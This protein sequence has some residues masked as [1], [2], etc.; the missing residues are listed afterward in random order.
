[1]FWEFL[2]DEL[3]LYLLSPASEFKTFHVD[4]T[5]LDNALLSVLDA[6]MTALSPPTISK[7][8]VRCPS[9]GNY[10]ENMV[11]NETQKSHLLFHLVALSEFMNQSWK[12]S[13]S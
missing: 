7:C 11:V 1:M 8:F 10:I 9:F 12:V 3:K 13:R 2:W 5:M 4:F 6:S